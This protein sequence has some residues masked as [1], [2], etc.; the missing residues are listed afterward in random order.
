M[1]KN[2]EQ[3]TLKFS[4]TLEASHGSHHQMEVFHHKL[5]LVDVHQMAKLFMLDVL[6]IYI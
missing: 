1:A 2:T 5:L 4:S 6:S 3:Q